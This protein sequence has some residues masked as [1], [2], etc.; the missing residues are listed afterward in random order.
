[1]TNP[2]SSQAA[3]LAAGSR[4]H[5]A[6]ST[7]PWLSISALPSRIGTAARNGQENGTSATPNM[8]VT[9]GDSTTHTSSVSTAH[10]QNAVMNLGAG[11][12]SWSAASAGQARRIR[13]AS[14]A[15]RAT[16][17]PTTMARKAGTDG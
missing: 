9:T 3:V 15:D 8:S 6:R 13:T 14:R 17:T 2:A 12:G 4:R 1:M 16:S 11:T 10:D 7:P 5:Q